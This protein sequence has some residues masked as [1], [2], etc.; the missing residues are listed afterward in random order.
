MA[1][2][3]PPYQE[4]AHWRL[5][6]KRDLGHRRN[7]NAALKPPFVH[8]KCRHIRGTFNCPLTASQLGSKSPVL[9]K[10]SASADRQS[11]TLHTSLARRYLQI[12]AATFSSGGVSRHEW[13]PP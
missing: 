12:G 4:L 3:V 7:A 13:S 2:C 9:L 1:R 5:F 6:H 11:L 10:Y 8:T